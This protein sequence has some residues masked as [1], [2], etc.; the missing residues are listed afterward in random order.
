MKLKLYAILSILSLI[1]ATP[2]SFQNVNALHDTKVIKG[3]VTIADSTR[4][5]FFIFGGEE[6]GSFK[7]KFVGDRLKV[8]KIEMNESPRNGYQYHVGF[9]GSGVGHRVLKNSMEHP[10][11]V[12]Y[13]YSPDQSAI[14]L[15]DI[16]NIRSIPD[17]LIVYENDYSNSIY[18]KGI[19]F[20]ALPNP[21]NL[22]PEPTTYEYD[23]ATIISNVDVKKYEWKLGERIEI[24]PKLINIGNETITLTTYYL[25]FIVNV[26]TVKG[27]YAWLFS[28]G[29]PDIGNTAVLE[30]GVPWGMQEA[31]GLAKERTAGNCYDIKLH[32]A[33]EYVVI[34]HTSFF[35]VKKGGITDGEETPKSIH[36]D[37]YSKPVAIRVLP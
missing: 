26:Y 30:P 20:A 21:K 29:I 10:F 11:G 23:G 28:C 37:I 7:M 15:N 35:T 33:G 14:L 24:D 27:N 4:Y 1:L 5:P 19:G 17:F 9:S 32:N 3:K 31:H 18:G 12:P 2:L 16:P 8:V 13:T 6:V 36:A 25:P 34:S 22:N